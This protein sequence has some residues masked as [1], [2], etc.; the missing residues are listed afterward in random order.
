MSKNTK[1]IEERISKK[2][3]KSNKKI[4][5]IIA[6]VISAIVISIMM[7]FFTDSLGLSE[8][9][10][11]GIVGGI[12]VGIIPFTLF[13]VKEMK[14]RDSL[15]QNL[16]VFLLA[17]LSAVRTGA[18]IENAIKKTSERNLGGLTP[19]LKN[20]NAN[21]GWGFPLTD[22]FRIFS[23]RC[24]TRISKRVGL[25]LEM[26]IRIGGDITE[27]LEMIQKHV[28]EMMEL[29]KSRKSALAPYV[30]TIYISFIVF[31]AIALLLTTNF[32]PEI[33]NVKRSF[34]ENA[35]AGSDFSGGDMF[36]SLQSF[37]P[38]ALKAMMFNM[39]IIE[40]VFGG[41]AVGKIGS[42]SYIAGVK[43]IVIMVVVTVISFTF[44]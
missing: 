6:S 19:E 5:V 28:S 21:L 41:L 12:L 39:A 7:Y 3:K 42:G 27:N 29:E 10:N 43:H 32:V 14:K 26:A 20:L 23:E 36:G 16:P 4:L 11:L 34:E 40:G 22:C 44:V 2:S 9:K 1:K 24:N 25:L 33:E 15:D 18:T 38:E 37:D 30:Y 31:L 13:Q 35:S 8:F 17:L